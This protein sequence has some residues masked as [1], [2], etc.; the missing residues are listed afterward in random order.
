M[1][2][3]TENAEDQL[4]KR[5]NTSFGYILVRKKYSQAANRE[6]V[7]AKSKAMSEFGLS[8]INFG[9]VDENCGKHG[10]DEP[11]EDN[12]IVYPWAFRGEIHS[13]APPPEIQVLRHEIGH[14]FFIRFLVPNTLAYQYGGDAP[15]WFDEM[16]AV[17]FEGQ[18]NRALRRCELSLYARTSGL[19]SFKRFLSMT[20]P[21]LR[22]QESP[23][24]T[25]GFSSSV[26]SNKETP[27]FYA[28]VNG[29]DDY[30]RTRLKGRRVI[31][32]LATAFMRGK[33]LGEFIVSELNLAN[34]GGKFQELDLDFKAWMAS[35]K[36]MQKAAKC[37]GQR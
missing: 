1:L 21:E 4:C 12:I 7:A 2:V 29:F 22:V 10:W 32:E 9:I 5:S 16:A 31:P 19:L 8:N 18:G 17:S 26:S 20:H 15:D 3:Q 35:D 33:P 14:S 28:M 11:D 36:R 13:K 24:Q 34:E 30:L 23:S 37:F 25:R 6:G 27:I